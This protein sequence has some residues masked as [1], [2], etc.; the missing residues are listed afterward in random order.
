MKRAGIRG[1]VFVS[2]GDPEKL[3]LF[4]DNNPNV[5]R[6]TMFVDD[7][8]GLS[9]YNTAGFK[10]SFAETLKDTEELK[11]LNISKFNPKLSFGQ[12]IAYA[13][14][15]I[16]MS[17]YPKGT[18]VGQFAQDI[19]LGNLPE[20]G[21]RLGGTLVVNQDDVVYQWNDQMPGDHPDIDEVLAIAE[22]AAQ[23]TQ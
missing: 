23:K 9:A 2:I 8:N 22:E 7:A 4:F 20:A 17:P 12:Y 6:E 11:K 1:P 14:D 13:R 19:V 21:L 10:K 5:P 15:F 18:G 3:N 16:K